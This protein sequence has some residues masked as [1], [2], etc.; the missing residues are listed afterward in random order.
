MC[1]IIWQLLDRRRVFYWVLS[2]K[3]K[4]KSFYYDLCA[5]VC[6]HIC[7]S[8][9]RPFW[10][11]QTCEKGLTKFL[12]KDYKH[13]PSWSNVPQIFFI[14][15]LTFRKTTCSG[16][17]RDVVWYKD[18]DFKENTDLQGVTRNPWT[19]MTALYVGVYCNHGNMST[20]DRTCRKILT[21]NKV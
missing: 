1:H 12:H 13:L 10:T 7:E 19:D 3:K 9:F 11:G 16:A 14:E 2:R 4:K 20:Y 17:D 6:L 18:T 21:A 15:R 5:F 8:A